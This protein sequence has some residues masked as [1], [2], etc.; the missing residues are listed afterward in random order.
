[1]AYRSQQYQIVATSYLNIIGVP[2]LFSDRYF[3]ELLYLNSDAG[4]TRIIQ[5]HPVETCTI[6]F[7]QGAIDLDTPDEYRAFLALSERKS[8]T[9][10]S[11]SI[12]ETVNRSPRSIHT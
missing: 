6:D 10:R 8:F 3:A 5:Q 2:A 1:M 11:N 9:T 4:A 7:P 12:L